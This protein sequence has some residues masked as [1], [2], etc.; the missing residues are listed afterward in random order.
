MFGAQRR[1]IEQCLG[2]QFCDLTYP[3]PGRWRE[4]CPKSE[5]ALHEEEFTQ[6][7]G[8][9]ACDVRVMLELTE[10]ALY[11]VRMDYDISCWVGYPK[12][13][14]VLQ[15]VLFNG[16]VVSGHFNPLVC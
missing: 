11:V 6:N 14:N 15:Y 9:S 3:F 2:K 12:V 5:G 13:P 10:T 4:V 7:V 16:S 1:V 8:E